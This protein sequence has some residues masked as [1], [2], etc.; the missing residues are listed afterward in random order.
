MYLLYVAILVL[1]SIEVER[2]HPASICREPPKK[3]ASFVDVDE[4]AEAAASST[5]S[6]A[7]G[8]GPEVCDGEG[9]RE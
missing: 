6:N 8:T 1:A 3:R 7:F 2:F 5:G 9:V 4:E